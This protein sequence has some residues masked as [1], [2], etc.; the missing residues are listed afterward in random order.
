MYVYV[1]NLKYVN[2]GQRLF[3]EYLKCINY[4]FIDYSRLGEISENQVLF[5]FHEDL[6]FFKEFP[7]CKIV[8]FT[9]DLINLDI[10]ASVIPSLFAIITTS[11]LQARILESVFDIHTFA[12]KEPIDPYYNYV[13]IQQPNCAEKN[14]IFFGHSNSIERTCSHLACNL[15]KLNEEVQCFIFSDELPPSFHKIKNINFFPFLELNDFV[16]TRF[17][18][19]VISDIP[20]D[21]SVATMAKSA[22]KLISSIKSGML[23]IVPKDYS[24]IGLLPEGYPY[25][26][27]GPHSIVLL[28]NQ[29]L[30][31]IKDYEYLTR[32]RDE[33]LDRYEESV[34]INQELFVK[35]IFILD[36]A[37]EPK[38][39]YTKW[40]GMYYYGV[41]DANITAFKA[42]SNYFYR[43][44]R[45]L[46]VNF[47]DFKFWRGS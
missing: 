9:C 37:V 19:S 13:K 31:V 43:R 6:R 7:R 23:P 2:A 10:L 4:S 25:I 39:S 14:I 12:I 16:N 3:I 34:K 44:F 15:E 11:P 46:W 33:I 41:K 32:H 22:N 35:E 40:P 21:L 18:Y 17:C 20:V 26:Y 42:T 30:N 5:I 28:I 27:T 29:E 45:R 38:Q 8:L 36:R 1:H 47:T 24:N